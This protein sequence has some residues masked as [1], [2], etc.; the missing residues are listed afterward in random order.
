MRAPGAPRAFARALLGLA[1]AARGAVGGGFGF[2]DIGE[3]VKKAV[4]SDPSKVQEAVQKVAEN[5][6]KAASRGSQALKDLEGFGTDSLKDLEGLDTSKA[7]DTA[8]DAVRTASGSLPAVAITAG[9]GVGAGEAAPETESTTTPPKTESEDKAE[10]VKKAVKDSP[11]G[12]LIRGVK[13]VTAGH[14]MDTIKKADAGRL[15]DVAS[16]VTEHG[17]KVA[18]ALQDATVKDIGKAVP[19]AAVQDVVQDAVGQALD[20][21][22]GPGDVVGTLSTPDLVDKAK[23]VSVQGA[24]ELASTEGAKHGAE[25][26]RGATLDD[27]G[28][29]LRG[30]KPEDIKRVAANPKDA[31][32]RI[33]RTQPADGAKDDAEGEEDAG[34]GTAALAVLAVLGCLVVGGYLLFQH[35]TKPRPV[36]MPMLTGDNE[37]ENIMM[38]THWMGSS[39]REVIAS[40]SGTHPGNSEGFTRF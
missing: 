12:G 39:A 11:L 29:S 15:E 34:G 8:K 22:P 19:G 35:L 16:Q 18:E 23:T 2:K 32:N 6:G 3:A 28:H 14:V 1:L 4:P 37:R 33:G 21:L 38:T 36:G 26:I 27:L 5:P 20:K 9:S 31:I 40:S 13:D 10:A 7:V 17:Q 30:A 25:M 24:V